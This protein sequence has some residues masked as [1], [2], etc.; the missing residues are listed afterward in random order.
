MGINSKYYLNPIGET[1]HHANGMDKGMDLK[2][3]TPQTFDSSTMKCFANIMAC[4]SHEAFLFHLTT[5]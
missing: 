5:K 1:R 4:I 2:L 3:L